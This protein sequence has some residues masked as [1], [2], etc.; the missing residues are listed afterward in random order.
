MSFVHTHSNQPASS[1]H[2]KM[3]AGDISYLAFAKC[4]F[5]I[6]GGKSSNI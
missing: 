3:L 4:V 6:A 1:I 5:S 2:K